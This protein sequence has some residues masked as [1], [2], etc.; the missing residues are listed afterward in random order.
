MPSPAQPSSVPSR[1]PCPS[2]SPSHRVQRHRFSPFWEHDQS[3]VSWEKIKPRK[4]GAQPSLWAEEPPQSH[5]MLQILSAEP[6]TA[7]AREQG[8]TDMCCAAHP[9]HG[10]L[11]DK[12]SE[13]WKSC[14]VR[15]PGQSATAVQRACQ[16]Y[17]PSHQAKVCSSLLREGFKCC[18]TGLE[19]AESSWGVGCWVKE[20]GDADSTADKITGPANSQQNPECFLCWASHKA[21]C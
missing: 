7:S 6:A 9:L 3:T 11:G 2:H 4:E 20:A 1:H 5:P 13:T 17:E 19:V 18:C 10:S 21:L 8:L 15:A 12:V 16:S 14:V